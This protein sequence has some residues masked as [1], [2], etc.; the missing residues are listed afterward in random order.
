VDAPV[1]SSSVHSL[2]ARRAAPGLPRF[3]VVLALFVASGAT[4]LVD[5]L[6]FSKYLSYVVGSTAYAVS[7]V[8]AA[9]MTGLA[10]GA[11][12]GGR[13]SA[14]ITRPLKI[15][16]LLE[17]L[18]AATVA[19]T[20]LAFRALTPLYATVARSMPGSLFAL[21]A[22]RWLLALCLVVLPTMA[23]GATLPFLTRSVDDGDPSPAAGALRE[24]RLNAL[25]AINTFGGAL[26]ALAAAYLIL[27]ALGM[28]GTIWASAAVSAAIGVIALALGGKELA[29]SP[30]ARSHEHL[31]HP[32]LAGPEL[33]RLYTL[34]FA[35]GCL[36]FAAE[37]V[38]THLLA[39]IIGNSA[40][41]FGLIL[42]AFLICLAAWRVVAS[43]CARRCPSGT[44][45]LTFSTTPGRSSP[46]SRAARR[47][48]AWPPS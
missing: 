46:R 8:L 5:Q 1:T 12:R 3:P 40:Y 39:L 24:K 19:A 15:Y 17:L 7:A 37:V 42:A 23:M 35:S 33:G 6:C 2:T 29:A 31:E 14:R 47:R 44:S 27:P 30:N 43:R 32:P 18:V 48:A 13:L 38:F 36:V 41:A 25:Y 11:H 21:S 10:L 4:G 16:G 22:L 28:D 20:P 26:G 45:C 9:F 34:A